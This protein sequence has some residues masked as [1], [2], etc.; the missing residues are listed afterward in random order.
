MSQRERMGGGGSIAFPPYR[1]DAQEGCLWRGSRR[2][3]L[4]ATD[5]AILAYLVSRAGRLVTRDELLGALWPGVAVTPG[6]V[7]VRV[8]RLRRTLRDRVSRPRFIETVHGRG[9]RFIAKVSELG[10]ASRDFVGRAADA[11]PASAQRDMLRHLCRAARNAIRRRVPHEAIA[12]ARRAIPLLPSL[13]DPGERAGTEQELRVTLGRLELVRRECDAPDVAAN[14][15]RLRALCDARPGDPSSLPGLVA[16]ARFELNRGAV[17]T[18]QELATRVHQL[19]EQGRHRDLAGAHTLLGAADFNAGRLASAEEHLAR[20]LSLHDTAQSRALATAYGENV[21]V[22]LHAYRALVL[23]HRGFPQRALRA[24]RVALAMARR[25]GL[26]APMA[27]ALG[28]AAWLHRLRGEAEAT[29]GLA[30]ELRVIATEE[31]FPFWLAQ[32]TFELGWVVAACGQEEEGREMMQQGLQQYRATGAR[33]YDVGDRIALFE[34]VPGTIAEH[35]AEID[36]LITSVA[37]TGQLCHESALHRLK[38][39]WLLQ[40]GDDD[41]ATAS[42]ERAITVAAAQG[43]SPLVRRAKAGLHRHLVRGQR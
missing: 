11:E 35:G 27:F 20:A 22:P 33:L 2:I 21:E 8:R 16:I 40:R 13:T 9:Y 15:A 1:L 14:Y 4:S 7:K 41:A 18:A 42:F 3:P 37:R 32:A 36:E 26:P 23:W 6:V 43:A 39:E 30:T 24:S 19:A 17:R 12:V 38:A 25:L 10:L 29:R 34:V 31:D 28:M 5:S